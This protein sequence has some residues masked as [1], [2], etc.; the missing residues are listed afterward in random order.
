MIALSRAET[1]RRLCDLRVRLRERGVEFTR[2][3]TDAGPVRLA[4][5][6]DTCGNLVQIHARRP[7]G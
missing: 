3:P 2:R 7:A 4:V 5:F 1:W 6:A